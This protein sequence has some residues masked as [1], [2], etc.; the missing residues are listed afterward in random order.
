VCEPAGDHVVL[1]GKVGKRG[2]QRVE[3]RRNTDKTQQPVGDA[4]P[5]AARLP[6]EG[7]DIERAGQKGE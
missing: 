4:E 3:D 2:H 7:P 1:I 5:P 6:L